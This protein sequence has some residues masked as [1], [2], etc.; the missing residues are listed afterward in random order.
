MPAE[1]LLLQDCLHLGVETVEAHPHIHRVQ[2]YEDT[3]CRGQAQ[4]GM[5]RSNRSR[6]CTESA[7]R[8]R[9]FR[10]DG[11]STSIAHLSAYSGA[12][13]I[14]LTSLN[15]KRA[16][17]LGAGFVLASHQSNV[18]RGTPNCRENALRVR[19]L[20]RNCSTICSR[21]GDATGCNGFGDFFICMHSA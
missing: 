11:L 16:G 7:S 14:T 17:V 8:Q 12:D 18:A 6:V 21:S 4:H 13:P 9:I 2:G 19:P 5:P 1:R 20:R 3:S 10:P 15:L